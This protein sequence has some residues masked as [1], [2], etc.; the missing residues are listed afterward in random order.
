MVGLLLAALVAVNPRLL[1]F[2]AAGLALRVGLRQLPKLWRRLRTNRTPLKPERKPTA[3]EL[4]TG[5]VGI[6][7]SLFLGWQLLS[8][9]H[10]SATGPPSVTTAV[11]V[12]Y[13][14]Q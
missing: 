13:T 10:Y 5:I 6:G 1:V 2:V 4:V 8:A 9:V 12:D 11:A 7:G 14:G 3:R